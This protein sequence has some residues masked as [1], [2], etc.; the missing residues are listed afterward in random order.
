MGHFRVAGLLVESDT[1]GSV[2]WCQAANS[3]GRC[4][5]YNPLGRSRHK[6]NQQGNSYAILIYNQS[7]TFNGNTYNS[8]FIN[9]NATPIENNADFTLLTLDANR[10][11]VNSFMLPNVKLQNFV[12][13]AQGNKYCLARFNAAVSIGGQTLSPQGYHDGVLFKVNVN[14]QVEWVV[15]ISGRGDVQP[16]ALSLDSGN[17]IYMTGYFVSDTLRIGTQTLIDTARNVGFSNTNAN[18]YIAQI[19]PLGQVQW[20]IH[21]GAQ[22]STTARAYD[23]LTDAAGKV[24]VCGILTG[25]LHLG[26]TSLQS[27]PVGLSNFRTH[28]L[29][30]QYNPSSATFDT[31]LFRGNGRSE[32][33][34]FVLHPADG[35]IYLSGYFQDSLYT[36]TSVELTPLFKNAV[37]TSQLSI[38]QEKMRDSWTIRTYSEEHCLYPSITANRNGGLY[39][40]AIHVD[41]VSLINKTLN[42]N[43]NYNRHGL[44]AKISGLSNKLS[45][46]AGTYTAV[47][48]D[49]TY[50]WLD[51]RA[52]MQAIPGATGRSYTPPQP[53]SYA[54][55][56]SNNFC[57]VVSD[58]DSG[59]LSMPTTALLTASISPNPFTDQLRISLPEKYHAE[60]FR[61]S[62]ADVT[63]KSILSHEGSLRAINQYLSHESTLSALGS[64][65][66]YILHLTLKSSQETVS[67]KI[68]KE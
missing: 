37:F 31:L 20:A 21:T 9:N 27:T 51:C 68:I 19:N 64:K 60:T 56:V 28:A 55:Q 49:A 6:S 7:T 4:T 13:D 41:T 63:G 32:A 53:G 24:Y 48:A 43:S 10:Q 47:E 14:N 52:N 15:P 8:T 59:A 40:S 65:Q 34:N 12:V 58:C 39:L 18:I 61:I 66:L 44:I 67:Y 36:S 11:T 17:N 57:T 25:T 3:T 29:V 1:N 33:V 22:R 62:I 30:L 45:Y 50:Q 54:V 23:I 46:S 35:H 2:V 16:T 42:P 38:G 26:N 5:F